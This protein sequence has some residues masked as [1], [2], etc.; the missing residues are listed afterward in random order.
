MKI[1]LMVFVTV[2]I[3]LVILSSCKSGGK[4]A[5]KT[6]EEG[7]PAADTIRFIAN[8][9]LKPAVYVSLKNCIAD[10]ITWS[11]EGMSAYHRLKFSELTGE[12]VQFNKKDIRFFI[13]DTSYI[14]VIMN[15]CTNG[16][17]YISK[18]TFSM[19]GKI[20]R[21][22]SAINSFDPKYAV[23]QS[24]V[25]YTDRGNIFVEDMAT[26]K[27][28]MMTFGKITDLDYNA[29]HETLDSVN[30]TPQHIWAKVKIE[31]KWTELQKNITL[32]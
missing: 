1:S 28:A 15:N 3:S 24:L 7:C 16:Q 25:A 26:G 29:I 30:I 32:E 22:N 23:D 4:E 13:K 18:I 31:N 27:K 12:E 19:T 8:H 10:S 2:I 20:F 5:R 9:P 6:C 14:W 11:N 17:G 21:K